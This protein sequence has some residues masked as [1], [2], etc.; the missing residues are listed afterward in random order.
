[1]ISALDDSFAEAEREK[2]AAAKARDQLDQEFAE[3]SELLD[4]AVKE[5]EDAALRTKLEAED[6]IMSARQ[7]SHRASDQEAKAKREREA[8]R[9]AKEEI[10]E[11]LQR[12]NAMVRAGRA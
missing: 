3:R 1:M 6:A 10:S 9:H 11:R 8:L 12:A 5:R 7:T 4:A 2:S